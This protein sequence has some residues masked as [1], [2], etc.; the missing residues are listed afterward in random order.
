MKTLGRILII[1]AM[2]AL[3]MGITYFVVNASG[4]ST[5]GMPFEDGE[6]PQF[7]NG[8]RPFSGGEE[9]FQPGQRPE[10][11]EGRERDGGDGSVFGMMGGFVKNTVIIGVIVALIAAPRSWWRNRN[12]STPVAA[13]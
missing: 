4:T 10:G 8:E 3:V 7:A 9:Q 13:E 11:F 1:L 12:R 6:R 2:F 5:N